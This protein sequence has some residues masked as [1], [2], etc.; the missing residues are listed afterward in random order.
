MIGLDRRAKQAE[1]RRTWVRR[2]LERGLCSDCSNPRAPG[3]RRYC[4][5]HRRI[6]NERRRRRHQRR[7]ARS[8]CRYCERPLAERSKSRCEG[9]LAYARVYAALSGAPRDERRMRAM[10]A[11][12]AA[13]READ[14]A[15]LIQA[16]EDFDP[17]ADKLD[18]LA[19]LSA[20]HLQ[21]KWRLP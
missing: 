21:H 2:Q 4:E 8:T 3:D 10:R 18:E 13:E 17:V 7:D 11:R 9:H 1:Y 16:P 19:D 20:M 12:R 5:R 15:A 6:R 14:R